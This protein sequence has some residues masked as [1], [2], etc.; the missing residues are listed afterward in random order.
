MP[1]LDRYAAAKLAELD[2]RHLRRSLQDTFREDGIWVERN[3]RRLLSF[4]CN[5]YLNL[6]QHPKVKRAA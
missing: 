4:S 5:D 6:T 1:S 3:G 2:R